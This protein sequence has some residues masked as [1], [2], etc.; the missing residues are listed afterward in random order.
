MFIEDS[1]D[2]DASSGSGEATEEEVEEAEWWASFAAGVEAKSVRESPTPH[3][4]FMKDDRA[5]VRG[6]SKEIG[7]CTVGMSPGAAF[8]SVREA[9]GAAAIGFCVVW[10]GV[11]FKEAFLLWRFGYG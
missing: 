10:F 5:R 11:G 4:K 2:I 6:L 9:S 3:E 1:V 7:T 8:A